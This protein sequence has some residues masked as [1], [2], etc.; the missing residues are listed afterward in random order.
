MIGETSSDQT[1]KIFKITSASIKKTSFSSSPRPQ[2]KYK[3]TKAH[4]KHPS[5]MITFLPR[6]RKIHFYPSSNLKLFFP[7]IKS[8]KQI[9]N[10]CHKTVIGN[11]FKD[12]IEKKSLTSFDT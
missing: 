2:E 1:L 9:L 3:I 5:S 7:F 10:R 4:S 12:K 8:T 6:R 11:T